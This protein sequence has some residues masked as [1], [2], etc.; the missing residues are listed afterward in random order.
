MGAAHT[1]GD[2]AGDD[3]IIAAFERRGLQPHRWASG[4]GDT[5]AAHE[6]AYRKVLYC[7]RGSITFTLSVTGQKITLQPGDRL[8]IEPRTLH[9]A[10]VGAEGCECI[11]AADSPER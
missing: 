2:G 4:P 11:E 6:H 10:G 7:L 1:R 3:E 8:E 5:Y 9:A